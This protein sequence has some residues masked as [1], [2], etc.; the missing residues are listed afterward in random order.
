[1]AAGDRGVSGLGNA[2]GS[3]DAPGF[4]GALARRDAAGRRDASGDGDASG[5]GEAPGAGPLENVGG[6]LLALPGSEAG[7][8]GLARALGW[9]CAAVECHRFPD[10]ES[11][12][13]LPPALPQRVALFCSLHDPDRKLVTLMLAAETARELGVRE[14]ILVAPYLCYMRQ[15]IAF[16]PGQAVSQRIVGRFLAR[17]FD[18]VITVDP[19]LHRIDRLSQAVPAQ[20]A[21]ALSAAPEIGRLLAG[22]QPRPLL[23]GPDAESLQWVRAAAE[24]GG[25][26]DHAVCEKTRLG[27]RSVQIRLPALPLA[28]RAVVL[29]DDVASSGHTLARAAA[30]ALAAGAASVDVAI[31]H[32]LFA[33]DALE[34]LRAAGVREIWSTD[35]IPHES[36]RIALAP[37]LAQALLRPVGRSG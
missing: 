31:T 2:A 24:A 25:G 22:R 37:L 19:H 21:V 28:G 30:Q 11:R 32:A 13:G 23:L 17:L 1:M 26:L 10:G 18:A 7:A 3:G 33:G 14:L 20:R 5:L 12:V 35:A 6:M 9:P 36:N 16:E 29:V 15:D 8:A 4:G 27:D 34:Q